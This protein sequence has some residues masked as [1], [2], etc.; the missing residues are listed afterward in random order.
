LSVFRFSLHKKTAVFCCFLPYFWQKTSL[1]S[2]KPS[3]SSQKPCLIS[4]KPCLNIFD[5]HRRQSDTNCMQRYK[6]FRTIFAIRRKN[7]QDL[8]QSR[9]AVESV[10]RDKKL[11]Y[12]RA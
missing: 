2:Q 12:E 10:N 7:L 8:T 11:I 5:L 1:I 6:T 3:L 4:P 9:Q